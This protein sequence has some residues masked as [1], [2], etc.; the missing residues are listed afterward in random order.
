MNFAYYIFLLLIIFLCLFTIK[1]NLSVSPKKIKIYFTIVLILLLM[2]HLGLVLLCILESSKY[3]YYLKAVIYLDNIAV[4]LIVLAV[5]YVY[6]RSERIKFTGSYFIL[7]AVAMVYVMIMHM[8]KVMVNVSSIY[9]FIMAIDNE[10]IISMFSL[11][12]IGIML[13]INV[14][15]L[16]KKYVNKKGIWFIIIAVMAVMIEKVIILGGVRIFPYS[17]IGE[18]I[19]IM[20]INFVLSGFKKIK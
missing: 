6:S 17:V 18:L 7:S 15:L 3:I 11:I 9:G 19:F 12:L 20:I 5:T 2:R 10:L 4:P 13:I 14:L 8:S 16:D 1:R